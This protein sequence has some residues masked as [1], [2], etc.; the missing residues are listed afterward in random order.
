[1]S[2]LR[3]WIAR[4]LQTLTDLGT[5]TLTTLR[6]IRTI[7][8]LGLGDA[9]D[10]FRVKLEAEMRPYAT[11][12]PEYLRVEARAILARIETTPL[13]DDWPAQMVAD[14]VDADD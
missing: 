10:F 2:K 4:I 7:W 11:E 1:M 8:R 13:P 14:V 3:T 12:F 6:V 9:D 5:V